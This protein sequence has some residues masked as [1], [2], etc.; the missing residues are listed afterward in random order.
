SFTPLLGGRVEDARV[1]DPRARS[2]G[3]EA[4]PPLHPRHFQRLH[5]ESRQMLPLEAQSL[6][7][8]EHLVEVHLIEDETHLTTPPRLI[9]PCARS[10]RCALVHRLS[11]NWRTRSSL[12]SVTGPFSATSGP[13]T[14]MPPPAVPAVPAGAVERAA[15]PP[16][17]SPRPDVS[18]RSAIVREFGSASILSVA[19]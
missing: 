2:V 13:C 5:S 4:S 18:A 6:R 12:S 10:V 3:F 9:L 16:E 1:F 14:A 8:W 7:G 11:A 17:G 19:S 15:S